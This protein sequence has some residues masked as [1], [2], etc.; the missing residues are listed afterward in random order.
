MKITN[1]NIKKYLVIL[2]MIL[3]INRVISMNLTFD[4]FQSSSIITVYP[5]PI[6][7]VQQTDYN[8]LPVTP[9]HSNFRVKNT[10]LLYIDHTYPPP[11]S[12]AFSYIYTIEVVKYDNLKVPTTQII[13]MSV[14]FDPN[15]NPGIS[16]KD[17][18]SFSFED[19]HR[20]ELRV[21]S[22]ENTSGGIVPNPEDNII[23]KSVIEIERYYNLITSNTSCVSFTT[24][25][26]NTDGVNDAL[27][28]TWPTI[29]G[30]ESYD[31]EWTWVDDYGASLVTPLS[32][33]TLIYDFRNNST[34][35][36]LKDNSF[37]LNLVFERGYLVFRV[38]AVGTDI[39]NPTYIINGNWSRPD[40]GNITLNPCSTSNFYIPIDHRPKFNWQYSSVYAEF[41]KK[42]EIVS[43]YDGSLRN[44]Q[45]VTIVNTDNNA[46]VGESIYDFNGRKAIDVLPVPIQSP[47]L[48]IMQI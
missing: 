12:S 35:V 30:A 2:L 20:V 43:Y 26:Y 32:A 47:A 27:E 17:K 19:A 14:E 16:Y 23:L 48:D 45:T 9:N 8:L 37:R 28:L 4:N 31:L 44:R 42:K 18:S 29:I 39:N 15:A 6:F 33:S 22:I 1:L 10:I 40:Y 36:N 5:A 11:I 41:G 25:D 7:A 3:S 21:L 38:R 13:K 24:N 46:I 34:R